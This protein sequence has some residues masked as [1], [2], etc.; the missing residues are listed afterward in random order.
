MKE[1]GEVQEVKSKPPRRV[2]TLGELRKQ[3][4]EYLIEHDH[5]VMV[6]R[7]N[8][9][10]GFFIPAKIWKTQDVSA[11]SQDIVEVVLTGS[12]QTH[13]DVQAC[14]DEAG[15]RRNHP[16]KLEMVGHR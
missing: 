7:N 1:D 15:K 8:V 11:Y 2:M 12:S 4:N 16:L 9:P 14:I 6:I 5:P 10:L 3:L 13:S